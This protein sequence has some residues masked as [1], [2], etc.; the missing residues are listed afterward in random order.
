MGSAYGGHT[1]LH[2]LSLADGRETARRAIGRSY[3]FEG[4][5]WGFAVLDYGEAP[6]GQRGA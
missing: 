6:L 4:I 2:D 1:R 5:V 3:A